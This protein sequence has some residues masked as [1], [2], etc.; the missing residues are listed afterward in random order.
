MYLKKKVEKH[1]KN[2]IT[3]SKKAYFFF[4]KFKLERNWCGNQ[5]L[6]LIFYHSVWLLKEWYRNHF[7]VYFL[8]IHRFCFKAIY[9][10]FLSKK[11]SSEN[12]QQNSSFNNSLIFLGQVLQNNTCNIMIYKKVQMNFISSCKSE[13]FVSIEF[14][15]K[16]C[17]K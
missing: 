3:D 13:Q 6:S 8:S 14:S 4:F 16:T 17:Q 7:D 1:Y 10:F 9:T 11:C 2:L 5:H 12:L 15:M